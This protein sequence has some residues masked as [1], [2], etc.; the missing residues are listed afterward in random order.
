MDLRHLRYFQAIAEEL[1]YSKAAVRLHVAQPALSRAVKEME[2]EVG[3]LLFE[4]NRSRV[5]LTPAGATLFEEAA[6]LLERFEESL[7]RVRR[8]ALGE[9]GKL[10]LGYIGPPTQPFLG[11][12]LAEYRR[13]FPQVSL[14]LE[15]PT[16][17]RVWEMVAKGRLSLGLTRPVPLSEELGLHTVVLRRERLGIV[18]PPSHPWEGKAGLPWTCLER[19]P[20]IVLARRERVGLHDAV[21][22]E[23]CHF[24]RNRALSSGA[25][26]ALSGG[27]CSN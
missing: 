1:G 10:R 13:L 21:T 16:P 3:A 23:R 20:L 17:E 19:E 26:R 7:R 18:I 11:R 14:H 6:L 25:R 8:T 27:T 24:R 15:E 5:R 2:S 4:R 22:P 12:L 9:E